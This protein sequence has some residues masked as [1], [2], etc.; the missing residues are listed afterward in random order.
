MSVHTGSKASIPASVRGLFTD[1]Y[2]A[3]NG[4]VCHAKGVHKKIVT[5]YLLWIIKKKPITGY[6]IMKLL[7]EE[8]H[9]ALAKASRIYPFLS[10]LEGEG[11]IR[12]KRIKKGRRESKEYSIT[13]KGRLVLKVTNRLM[14]QM[15]WGEFLRDISKR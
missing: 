6:S 9:P 15:M 12:S 11:L 2:S 10:Y 7:R 13:Q 4:R 5:L 8:Q 1:M 14:S 3:R